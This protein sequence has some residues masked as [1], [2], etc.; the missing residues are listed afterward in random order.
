[1]CSL[2]LTI[3]LICCEFLYKKIKEVGDRNDRRGK[4]GERL[5]DQKNERRKTTEKVT[6]IGRREKQS[7]GREKEWWG[8]GGG[9]EIKEEEE[10]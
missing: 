8:L 3:E 6:E 10:K 5:E 7:L 2:W 9:G 4:E 1:M